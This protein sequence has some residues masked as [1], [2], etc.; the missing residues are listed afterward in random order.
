M[1]QPIVSGKN[2]IIT[3]R[4]ISVEDGLPSRNVTDAVQDKNGFMWFATANGISRYDGNTFK[5]YNTHNSKIRFDDV[6]KLSLDSNN[7]LYI[8]FRINAVLDKNQQIFQLLDLNDYTFKD[9]QSNISLN[10]IDSSHSVIKGKPLYLKDKENQWFVLF[11][12]QY[13]LVRD[14]KDARLE[15]ENSIHSVFQDRRNNFWF[16]TPRGIYQMSIDEN[17]FQ[18]FF[19]SDETNKFKFST[20]GIFAEADKQHDNKKR[21]YALS[22]FQNFRVQTQMGFA[23]LNAPGGY[24]LLKKN[25]IFYIATNRLF[26]YD[27]DKDLSRALTTD[28][29]GN[30]VWSLATYS[31][32]ILLLGTASKI[33]F[34]NEHSQQLSS[35]LFLQHIKQLPINIYRFVKSSQKGWIAIAEN[36]IYFINN[37]FEVYDYFGYQHQQKEKRLPFTGIYDLHEDKQGIAWL[38]MNGDGLIRWNWNAADPMSK[39][40]FKK[41][42]VNDGLPDNILYRIEEDDRDNLWIS[43]YNGLL[44]LHK[45]DLTTKIYKSKD[46][47]AN[48]EF[49][50]VSSFKDKEGWMYFG[51]FNGID[52]FNPK[53]MNQDKD[54]RSLPFQLVDFTKFSEQQNKLIDVLGEFLSNKKMTMNAGDRF[55]TV[56]FSLLDF[57]KRTHRYRYRIEGMDKDWNYINENTIRISGLPY[58]KL[59]LRIE[60]QR[61]SGVWNTQEI[62]I[63]IDV[64]KPFYL[65]DWF[66]SLCLFLLILLFS[67]VYFVR[68][69]KLKRDKLKLES[70]IQKRTNSL[71][72]ALDDREMLLKEIHHR[73]KNNLQIITGLLQ[74][75]KDGL[76]DAA[77]HAALSEGQSRVSSIALIHQN[78]YQNK[79][80]GNIEFKVFLHDLSNQIAELFETDNK[81]VTTL[82]HLSETYLDIDTAVPLGLIVNELLTNSYKYAF[83][84]NANPIIE[85]DVKQFGGGVF[86]LMYRDNGPGI[87][88]TLDFENANSLGIKLIWGLAK[89][90]SGAVVYSNNQGSVFTI[91]FKDT[92]LRKSESS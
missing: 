42:T 63:P 31:D 12:N 78:L 2:Y 46:G 91:D 3:K 84:N 82:L 37:L 68:I 44:K 16:A 43:S 22:E 58:G 45:P 5:N 41:L 76:H 71:S 56:S 61:S 83:S 40:N 70:L 39:E 11:D 62:S 20:R 13:V 36:G 23:T 4:L 67:S 10:S 28:I 90:L 15:G 32:S 75:Q 48:A 29:I 50:R 88:G 1:A 54:D 85:I 8:D 51:G 17:K 89:Q 14:K 60:A 77:A 92:A 24:A 59:T 74:L 87:Q 49:N 66:W 6:I 52:A 79:E 30:P 81:K 72:V 80:L 26:S 18:H 47:L 73:V 33:Y 55:L 7:H 19:D 21:V 38:A 57:E 9:I 34:Y 86:Q 35:A 53:E 27:P 64:L 25:G 69:N 65:Q